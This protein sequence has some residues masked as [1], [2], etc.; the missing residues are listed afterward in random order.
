MADSPLIIKSK[1][2]ALEVIQVCKDL[3]VVK[4]AKE[5]NDG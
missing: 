3:R 1:T 4:C 5:K 2:F